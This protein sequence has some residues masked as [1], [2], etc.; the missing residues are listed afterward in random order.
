MK[1]RTL[2]KTGLEIS[3]LGFGGA[4]MGNLY[5]SV[6][7]IEAYNSLSSA[8]E[9]GIR[10]FD[11]APFYGYGL[12]ERR[13]G[14][15]LRF[16]PHAE[17]LISTTVGRL[18]V[19]D[20]TPKHGDIFPG[21]L[22]FRAIYDYTY[23]GV[24]RSFEHSIQRLGIDSIDILFVHDIDH[25]THGDAQ[26]KMC[27]DL[28]KGGYQALEELRS[29][30]LVKAIGLGV[31]EWQSCLEIIPHT[32][33]DCIMLSGRYTLLEQEPLKAFFPECDRRKIAIIAAGPYNSGILAHGK[34]YNYMEAN[35][36]VR[37]KV[38]Q[39]QAVCDSYQI[40]LAHAAISFPLLNPQIVS[41]VA[42]LRTPDQV[43]MAVNYIRS[44]I[45]AAFW[46]ELKERNLIVKNAPVSGK[47]TSV[48]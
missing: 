31:N 22:P 16:R 10:Y 28:L 48:S 29:Q 27:E 40:E 33:L 47:K 25:Y 20:A 9:Q 14:D 6:S 46:E 34:Y 41:V 30:K 15:A 17:F 4:E 5:R 13:I 32:D 45:P 11:T 44:P 24:M 42:G 26:E 36:E 21:S 37:L 8:W 43:N 18:L 39:L 3:E 38:E 7:N 19:P 1:T 2:G 35:D 23:D 12:S